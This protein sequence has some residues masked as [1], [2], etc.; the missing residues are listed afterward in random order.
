MIAGSA[1]AN[2][3]GGTI[4]DVWINALFTTKGNDGAREIRI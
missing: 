4:R 2:G 3:G 1:V